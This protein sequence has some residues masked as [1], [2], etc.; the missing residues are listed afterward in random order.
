[1]KPLRALPI[2]LLVCARC[3]AQEPALDA[4][5]HR[6]DEASGTECARASMQVARRLLEDAHHLFGNNS[7]AAQNRIDLA[8][9]Y[10][11]RAVDCTLASHK[12]EKAVEVEMRGLIRRTREVARSV[13]DDD[14]PRV[15]QAGDQMEKQ[16]D[17]LL[18]AIFGSAALPS[19]E[20][21]P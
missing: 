18:Q 6:A 21:V 10:A 15:N 9:H 19:P 8:V 20:A 3:L 17:R 11:T 2:V 5:Q 13:E 14:R 7:Q 16:R 1:M 12:H 4:L